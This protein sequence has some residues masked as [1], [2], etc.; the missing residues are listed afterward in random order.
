MS[1]GGVGDC[2]IRMNGFVKGYVDRFDS[3]GHVRSA[4]AYDGLH[5]NMLALDFIRKWSV[6]GQ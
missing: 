6:V 1:G 4:V 3:F 5:S 2:V